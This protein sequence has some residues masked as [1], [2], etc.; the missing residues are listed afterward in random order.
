MTKRTKGK[1]CNC[2]DYPATWNG[3]GWQCRNCGKVDIKFF[4]KAKGKYYEMKKTYFVVLTEANREGKFLEKRFI[5]ECRGN[6]NEEIKIIIENTKKEEGNTF[7]L[8]DI[9]K[10]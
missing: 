5:I 6:I 4:G 1:K 8:Y 2:Y 10:L 7:Y 9:R 3:E